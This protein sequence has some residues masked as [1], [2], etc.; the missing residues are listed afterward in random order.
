M[1]YAVI[2]TGSR[3]DEYI[4]V[5]DWCVSNGVIPITIATSPAAIGY[6]KRVVLAGEG[7][8][9]SRWWNVGIKYALAQ[10]DAEIILVLNDDITLPDGWLEKIVE[11]IRAGYT[12]ASTD[13]GPG[14][15]TIAGYAFGLDAKQ[16]VLADE[17]LVWW[18]GD[19]DIQRQCEALGGFGIIEADGV[20]NKYANS[21]YSK[22]EHQI[23]L[24][25]AT[26]EKK[27]VA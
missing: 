15:N 3:P 23:Q 9:I 10:K 1:I 25:R 17:S 20:T 19:D 13:R 5:H 8:N 12:G 24:D 22:M 11:A 14:R 4:S 16:K 27:W 26:Y 6:A 2:P 18:Y 7:L 21:S